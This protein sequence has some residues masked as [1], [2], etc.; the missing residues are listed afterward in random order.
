MLQAAL[1]IRPSP[2]LGISKEEVGRS[3]VLRFRVLDESAETGSERSD[4][5]VHKAGGW[6]RKVEEGIA[7][8]FCF[9]TEAISDSSKINELPAKT[10]L[11]GSHYLELTG[12]NRLKKGKALQGSI[13]ICFHSIAWLAGK[14]PS[15]PALPRTA[16]W[17]CELRWK[18]N[19]LTILLW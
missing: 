18:N 10:Y 14:I 19:P 15:L 1:L 13:P 16:V 12:H 4:T 9:I 8:Q 11:C 3:L 2:G 6:F 7:V 5:W 17:I